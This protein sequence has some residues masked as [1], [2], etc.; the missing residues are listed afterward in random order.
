MISAPTH[1]AARSMGVL[2][3]MDTDRALCNFPSVSESELFPTPIDWLPSELL[4]DVFTCCTYGEALVPL[5]LGRVCRRWREITQGTPRVW[6]L[7]SLD[8]ALHPIAVSRKQVH[9]WLAMSYPIPFD[10]KV[11]IHSVDMLLP[12]LS[13]ALPSIAR[14]RWLELTGTRVDCINL[15]RLQLDP[16]PLNSLIL[17][18]ENNVVRWGDPTFLLDKVALL[19]S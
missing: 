18:V 12:L 3:G 7:I 14:W 1:A 6:Q 15:A 10:V 4:I 5:T 2:P 13:P 19:M 17:R 11:N 8:D 16:S 9:L